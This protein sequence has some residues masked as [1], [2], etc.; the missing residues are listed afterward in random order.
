MN[1][2]IEILVDPDIQ[3]GNPVFRGT[4]VTVDILFEYI[5]S[6]KTIDA[7]ILDFPGVKKE[8]AIAVLEYSKK[9]ALVA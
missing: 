8:Q 7:F 5:E 9:L 3:G 2:C 4:R 6:G 1:T